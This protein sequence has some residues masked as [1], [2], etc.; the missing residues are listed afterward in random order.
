MIFRNIVL[1]I[2]MLTSKSYSQNELN[3]GSL[4][5]LIQTIES[6][7]LLKQGA[8]RV[9]VSSNQSQVITSSV[10]GDNGYSYGWLDTKAIQK[11]SVEK[12]T[13]FY[14]GEDRFWLNPLGSK[15]S[16]FYDQN[17]IIQ[18]NWQVPDLFTKEIFDQIEKTNTSVLFKKENAMITNNIGTTFIIDIERKIKIYTDQEITK[19]LNIGIPETV[20]KVGFSSTT[21]IVNKGNNW[22]EEKGLITPW[23][24]G[25]F[26]GSPTSI[27]IF[28]YTNKSSSFALSTYFFSKKENRHKIDTDVVYFKT[29]GAKRSKIGLKAKHCTS[30]IGNY[31]YRHKR[32]TIIKYSFDPDGIFLSSDEESLETPYHGDVVNSYNNATNNGQATFFELETTAPGSILK[33]NESIDH[34]HHTFHFEGSVEDLNRISK[35]ILG[36][37]LS[38]LELVFK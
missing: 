23:T 29:D 19:T 8:S 32:L 5:K 27:G 31:D 34:T 20:K 37:D 28:P 12:T 25:M 15:Y 13:F 2:V 22:S 35:S 24:I 30:V 26:K 33:K 11:N 10:N 7:I 6:P 14:G 4:T 21:T 1:A 38:K 16:L 36:C 9:L 18:K 3:F 17:K